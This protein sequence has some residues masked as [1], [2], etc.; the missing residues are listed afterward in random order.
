[1]TE[2]AWNCILHP[3][4]HL[5]HS[6]NLSSKTPLKIQRSFRFAARMRCGILCADM[7]DCH[8]PSVCVCP[9]SC[10]GVRRS[11]VRPQINHGPWLIQ[12]DLLTYCEQLWSWLFSSLT[13]SHSPWN[14]RGSRNM[15]AP[16]TH[17]YATYR[18]PT[19][20]STLKPQR[21]KYNQSSLTGLSGHC[22][23]AWTETHR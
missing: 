5:A 23:A 14:T 16:N 6:D 7:P 4:G 1:M 10:V 12:L 9:C 20:R 15:C 18:Q 11:E 17:T 22:L 8:F 2:P 21:V 13:F 3:W 19:L